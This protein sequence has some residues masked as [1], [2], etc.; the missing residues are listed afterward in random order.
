[1]SGG[2]DK[3]EATSWLIE[4]HF[5]VE[6]DLSAVYRIVGPNEDSPDEPIKLLEVNAAT[7]ATGSVEPFGFAPTREVPFPVVIA[8][9][10]PAEL[11]SFR[12]HPEALP[13]GWDLET[14]LVIRRP[15]A[16]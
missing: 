12:A 16:A 15:R 9:I 3:D 4:R 5:A 11:E 1:M 14:A 8:E 2:L 6:P 13:R 7:V 10:T